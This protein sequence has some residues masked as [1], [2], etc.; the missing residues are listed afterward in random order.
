M[1]LDGLSLTFTYHSNGLDAPLSG[2][3]VVVGPGAE[4]DSMLWSEADLDGDR[5]TL[6]VTV[7]GMV[8][9]LN[10]ET[11]QGFVIRDSQG[12]LPAFGGVTILQNDFGYDMSRTY[13]DDNEIQIRIGGLGSDK[14]YGQLGL[15]LEFAPTDMALS[16]SSIDE[17][18]AGAVI[19]DIDV[20]DFNVDEVFTY[21]VDDERF[22]VVDGQLK[23]KDGVALD[24]EAESSVDVTVTATDRGNLT[25]GET[26][27]IT[28][29]NVRERPTGADNTIRL[30]EDTQY[31]FSEADFGFADGDGDAF[32]AVWIETLPSSGS[33]TLL[34]SSVSGNMLVWA[35]DI[36]DLVWRP[37]AD[38]HGDG[39]AALTFRVWDD[40]GTAIGGLNEDAIARTITFDVTDVIDRITASD[41]DDTVLG[42][43][44][45]DILRGRGGNDRLFGYGGDDILRSHKGDDR[46]WGGDGADRFIY[47][48]GSGRDRILD[49]EAGI[50]T[51]DIRQWKAIEDFADL[52]SQARNKDGD[53]WIN[54]GKD[55]LIIKD[56]SKR[57]LDAGDFLI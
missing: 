55:A 54:D 21:T 23:L 15:R 13:Y 56:F 24:H 53:L 31:T 11:F 14:P 38:A 52:K 34:G 5:F 27:T 17:N 20:T 18:A 41:G 37:D 6:S 42:T 28:V 32:A 35:S 19:G 7:D 47:A 48:T 50:D 3:V 22:E 30:D 51:I 9:F 16:A 8:N 46:L 25:D 33:L 4:I 45:S 43:A 12:V 29:A 57:D 49:F 2:G 40:S 1:S 44:G 36:P 39:L 10:G 26:F